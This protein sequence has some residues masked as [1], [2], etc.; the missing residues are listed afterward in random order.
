[1]TEQRKKMALRTCYKSIWGFMDK[2]FCECGHTCESACKTRRERIERKIDIDP[3]TNMTYL[4]KQNIKDAREFYYKTNP[5]L[6]PKT[7]K[8]DKCNINI[9]NKCYDKN[10]N[11]KNNYNHLC[12]KF[13]E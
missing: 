13:C 4:G 10:H 7:Y 8:C 6:I 11:D 2:C 1:M 9:C 12:N 3:R 5:H